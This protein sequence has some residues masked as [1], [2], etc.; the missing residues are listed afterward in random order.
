MALWKKEKV[1][2]F[3]RTDQQDYFTLGKK[4][5]MEQNPANHICSGL[6]WQW[7]RERD[8]LHPLTF[9]L[10]YSISCNTK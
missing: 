4:K 5:R 7:E 1:D 8:I 2:K 6:V 10:S 9:P 3:Q